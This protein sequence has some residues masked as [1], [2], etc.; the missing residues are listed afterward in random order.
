MKRTIIKLSEENRGEY[1]FLG[2]REAF[3]NKIQK[4]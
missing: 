2:A 1:L 4:V 3:L